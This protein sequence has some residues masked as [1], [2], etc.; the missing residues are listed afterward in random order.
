MNPNAAEFVPRVAYEKGVVEFASQIAYDEDKAESDGEFTHDEMMEYLRFCNEMETDAEE[1]HQV[2]DSDAQQ[3]YLCRM[4]EY[5]P[6]KK[7]V[8]AERSGKI[9]KHGDD[10]KYRVCHH[11]HPTQ[12][13]DK[14]GVQICAFFLKGKCTK[15]DKCKYSHDSN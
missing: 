11:V 15:F 2:E 13:R 14:N 12:K 9:C 1:K 8:S 7:T 6:P 10:C 4:D 5:I 3:Y